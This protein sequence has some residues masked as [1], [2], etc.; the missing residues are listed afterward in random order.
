MISPYDDLNG[1]K[2]KAAEPF[3]VKLIAVSM[4]QMEKVEVED[5]RV[6]TFSRHPPPQQLD[7]LLKSFSPKWR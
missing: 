7:F 3:R 6:Q 1:F 5:S 4:G 2:S